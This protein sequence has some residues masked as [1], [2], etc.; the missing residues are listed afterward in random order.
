MIKFE[1][2]QQAGKKISLKLWQKWISKITK[3]LKLKN[4]LEISIAVV[5]DQRIKKLNATYRQ[6]NKVTDVLSFGALTKTSK[7]NKVNQQYLGEIVIGYQQAVRQ[8]NKIGHSVNQEF[9][10][11]LVHGF[12]HLL[13]YDH[14]KDNEAKTMEK[15]EQKIISKNI[16]K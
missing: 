16:N 6:K 12:L 1:V 2:N 5:G 8:S 3:T 14:E 4:D 9:E 10:K 15:L 13:G 11:L 7:F